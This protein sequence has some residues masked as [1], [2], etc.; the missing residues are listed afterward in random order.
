MLFFLSKCKTEDAVHMLSLLSEVSLS[1]L[2]P[3]VGH[4]LHL[5]KIPSL[6]IERNVP[7][8]F[9]SSASFRGKDLLISVIVSS[10]MDGLNLFSILN[11]PS[12]LD[13]LPPFV[14][15]IWSRPLVAWKHVK[16]SGREFFS[17]G[18]LGRSIHASQVDEIV[19]SPCACCHFPGFVDSHP[20]HVIYAYLPI[21]SR[22]FI[23]L[24]SKGTK[25]RS[26]FLSTLSA[27]EAVH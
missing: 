13:C 8:S 22:L 1:V 5:S 6:F 7:P 27:E 17:C 11:L 4:A 23:E 14:R 15:K 26:G 16:T 9:S 2:T 19:R 20:S 25:F 10:R 12:P 3:N 21:L 24:F 18:A